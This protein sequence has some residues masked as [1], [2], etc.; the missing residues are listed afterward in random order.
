MQLKKITIE[1][2]KNIKNITL[3][4]EDIVS[5]I[6]LN[7]YGKSN[8]LEGINFAFMFISASNKLRDTMMGWYRGIPLNIENDS[9]N[10]TVD[11]YFYEDFFYDNY[12]DINNN[13]I[14]YG[15]EFVCI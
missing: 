6:S 2:F 13:I 3:N 14:N 10:F 1:G 11:F 15:F 8:V 5:L 12:G 4:F 9:Q 7:N